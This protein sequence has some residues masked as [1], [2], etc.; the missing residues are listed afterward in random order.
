MKRPNSTEPPTGKDMSNCDAIIFD[1]DGVLLDSE[2][3]HLQAWQ[4][5]LAD[6]AINYGFEEHKQFLGRKDLFMAGQLCL[7]FNLPVSAAQL[8]CQKERCYLQLV[9]KHAVPRAGLLRLLDQLVSA[10]MPCALA[11]SATAATIASTLSVLALNSY[12]QSVSSGDDVE[13]GKPA[14]DVFLLAAGNLKVQPERC[15]VIE[16]T[17]N[18]I[19]AARSAGMICVAVPCASTVHEDHS[20]AHLQ[21]QSLEELSLERL[22]QLALP[23]GCP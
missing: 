23:L 7:R 12:F 11:S 17:R 20:L 9:E 19:L 5:L 10:G 13:N 14:P 15:V 16:D 2:P 4:M 3:L 18:G 21:L 8:T 22:R 1:M 6:F